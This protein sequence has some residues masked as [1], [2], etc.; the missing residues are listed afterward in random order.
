[1]AV[2]VKK[3]YRPSQERRYVDLPIPAAWEGWT[4]V[5]IASGPSLTRGQVTT[6]RNAWAEKRCKVLGCNDA[7][8]I[9]P[10]IDGLYASDTKWWDHHIESVRDT[11]IDLLFSQ[12]QMSCKKYGLWYTPGR[13]P[14]PH[15]PGLSFDPRCLVFGYNS[16]FSLF[17]LSIL[18]GVTKV[19]LIGYDCKV[20]DT[21]Q[22]HWF[23]DHPPQMNKLPEYESWAKCYYSTVDL[24]DERGIEV[25]NCSPGSAIGAFRRSTIGVEL[26]R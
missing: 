16:G 18:L 24:L 25:V 11:H 20:S 17:N 23:G 2:A 21:H 26:D 8:R 14:N 1:M 15:G 19:I 4:V 22:K 9:A 6:A 10:W 7:Y 12:C 13:S 3:R 5:L